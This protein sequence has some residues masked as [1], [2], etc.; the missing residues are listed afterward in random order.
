MDTCD[1]NG[2]K[3]SWDGE[4]VVVVE[5]GIIWLSPKGVVD[6]LV[7]VGMGWLGPKRPVWSVVLEVVLSLWLIGTRD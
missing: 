6:L 3:T 7:I 2:L 1:M 4:W 5:S